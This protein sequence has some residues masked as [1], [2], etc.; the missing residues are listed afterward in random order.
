M[1]KVLEGFNNEELVDRLINEYG[2]YI[3]GYTS[4]RE[5]KIVKDEVIR[6]MRGC[7]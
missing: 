5:Y 3:L 7:Q 1:I 2:N 6:R 4:K